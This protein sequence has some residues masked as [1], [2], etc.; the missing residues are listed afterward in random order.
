MG[1]L[2]PCVAWYH[3]IIFYFR[4]TRFTTAPCYKGKE[5]GG[6][7]KLRIRGRGECKYI[8]YLFNRHKRQS[9]KERFKINKSK[10]GENHPCEDWRQLKGRIRQSVR[11]YGRWVER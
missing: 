5:R 8:S 4:S 11:Y 2:A 7:L 9:D 6:S 10:V 3:A 1:S